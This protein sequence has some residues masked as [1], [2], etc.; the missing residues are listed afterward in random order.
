MIRQRG[1]TT[2]QVVV[3]AGHGP[4]GRERRIRRTVHGT[5]RRARDVE[6]QLTLDT[7]SGK[8]G[9]SDITLGE[10]LDQ[11]LE[12][13]AP[14]LSPTTVN[15]YRANIRLHVKVELGALK[16]SKLTPAR[17]DRHYSELRD[18]GLAPTTIRQVHA[19]I[20]R[21]L[22]QAVRWGWLTSNPATLAT[23]PKL[24]RAT[25]SPPGREQL[26]QF[27]VELL[28]VDPDFGTLVWVAAV[29]GARRGELVGL[30]WT[31]VDASAR[32]LLISR[33][34]VTTGKDMYVKDTKTHQSRR[35]ALDTV[36]LELL[37]RLRAR[38]VE[39]AQAAGITFTTDRWVFA[40]PEGGHLDPNALTGRYR[41]E[42]RARDLPGRLHDLRHFAATEAL[43]AGIPVR[44]V[45]GRLGH[46]SPATT[47][48]VYAHFLE[49]SD[50][51]AADTLGRIL[52]APRTPEM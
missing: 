18:Q 17:L 3:Y 8:Y 42:A 38:E 11:W 1:P 47:H 6:R 35:I 43:G 14:E 19:V 20:R 32:T 7:R 9:A 24:S 34:V 22:N 26:A 31:D 4:D 28:D 30:R 27:L 50:R 39:R 5:K 49:A 12:R 10:L 48:N 46:A 45:A 21:A 51:L 37:E 52:E 13:A 33:S 16:L 36:T 2:F 29:T 15:G 23:P 40:T 41:R 44:T 25:V